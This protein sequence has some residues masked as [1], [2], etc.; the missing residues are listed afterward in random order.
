MEMEAGTTAVALK[1]FTASRKILEGLA[2]N[3]SDYV[4]QS[5]LGGVLNNQA[6]AEENLG[7]MET[8]KRLLTQAIEV[9]RQAVQSA[10]DSTRCQAFLKEHE[11]HLL[12][13]SSKVTMNRD[14]PL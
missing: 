11:Q 10:P 12:R 14:Q 1:S 5:N 8:A 13:V 9:Q 2:A 7:N 3:S 4:I 6:L